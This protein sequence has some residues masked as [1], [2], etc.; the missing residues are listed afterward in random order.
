MEAPS[1]GLLIEDITLR[2][3]CIDCIS[4]GKNN[5]LSKSAA[6]HECNSAAKKQCVGNYVIG[7][8]TSSREDMENTPLGSRMQCRMNFTSRLISTKTLVPI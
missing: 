6:R 1:N 8:L 4:S 5:I 3:G 7:P 2:R